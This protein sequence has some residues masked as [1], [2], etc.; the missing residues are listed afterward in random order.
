LIGVR[1]DALT[2]GLSLAPEALI[3]MALRN[4]PVGAVVEVSP[5]Q[6]E[7]A[8]RLGAL[9]ASRG[10]AA[11]VIDY[12]RS[13]PG[14]GDTLQA[15][16][17]HRKVDPLACPGEA[18]LTAHVDFPAVVE[19]ARQAGALTTAVAP[20]GAFLM[21]LGLAER[22]ERLAA[23][24]P[25]QSSALLSQVERLAGPEAMGVLFKALAIHQPGLTPPGFEAGAAEGAPPR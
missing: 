7:W 14:A 17:A 5:A 21:S 25:Q 11:L 2:F 13:D 24:E 9:V 10:G 15:L 23:A 16:K 1:D 22:A 3:P 20:Q 19:A 6:A 8:R 18:D 4:S 12:G